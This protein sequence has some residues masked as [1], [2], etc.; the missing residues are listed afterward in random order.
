MFWTDGEKSRVPAKYLKLSAQENEVWTHNG[1]R[2]EM[3]RYSHKGL[4]VFRKKI[5]HKAQRDAAK[6]ADA[7][8]EESDA[9][10]E[11][12]DAAT[13]KAEELEVA[14]TIAVTAKGNADIEDIDEAHHR[15]GMGFAG[16]A[17]LEELREAGARRN[18][19]TRA[20][21][22]EIAAAEAATAEK[23]PAEEAPAD[24]RWIRCRQD[25]LSNKQLVVLAESL[26]KTKIPEMYEWTVREYITYSE[27]VLR[28]YRAL[29]KSPIHLNRRY[30]FFFFVVTNIDL[31][32]C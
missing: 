27:R 1:Y 30:Y 7:T 20:R 6:E 15:I 14:A 18:E 21:R 12:A 10:A 23:P 4:H 25:K 2:Y 11:K 31:Y 5:S 8:T 19:I 26:R 24:A 13:E 32:L 22:N 3:K 29:Q 16:E 17:Q 28:E 9:A